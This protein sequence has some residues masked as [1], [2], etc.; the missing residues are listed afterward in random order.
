MRPI[1][2][3]ETALL[4]VIGSISELEWL[5]YQDRYPD[6]WVDDHFEKTDRSKLPPHTSFRFKKDNPVVISI[7]REAIGSYKGKLEWCM[8][9]HP[10]EYG[11]G[12]NYRILPKFVKELRDRKDILVVN[13]YIGIFHPE[14][15]SIAYEDLILLAAHVRMKFESYG[16]S[17]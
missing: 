4:D 6:T 5:H 7:L 16:F 3:N 1:G 8:T 13:K 9:E 15:S 17:I 11:S 2:K 12:I 10:K 14:F